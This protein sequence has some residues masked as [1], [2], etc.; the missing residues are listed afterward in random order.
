MKHIKKFDENSKLN[1][2]LKIEVTPD[3]KKIL[4]DE[5]MVFINDTLNKVWEGKVAYITYYPLFHPH[6][7]KKKNDIIRITL[8]E[9]PS[10]RIKNEKLVEYYI[11]F[12]S[13]LKEIINILKDKFNIEYIRDGDGS[14][15]DTSY[16]EDHYIHIK[17]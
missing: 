5:D 7:Y 4:T 10:K 16:S 13:R 9:S 6:S 11:D 8:Q 1:E 14:P 12:Y 2:G 15:Y 3:A 17:M